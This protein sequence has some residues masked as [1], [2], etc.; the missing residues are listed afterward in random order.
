MKY[1]YYK[2]IFAEVPSYIYPNKKGRFEIRKRIGEVVLYWGTYATLEEAKL[3]RAYYI[4]KN[5]D[6][7]PSFKA[8]EYIRKQRDKFLI[9]KNLN[10]KQEY[11]GSFDDLETARRERDICRDCNWDY[12]LIVEM[13]V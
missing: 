5:W 2:G 11:F 1:I 3:W 9:I 6:V 8:N 10:G 7:N 4:G 12:D 13:E